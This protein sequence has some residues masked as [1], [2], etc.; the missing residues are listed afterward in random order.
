MNR[1]AVR[2]RTRGSGKL[3][4]RRCLV[5]GAS[6][7]GGAATRRVQGRA[8]HCTARREQRPP[9][10]KLSRRERV[11]AP[12]LTAASSRT[13]NSPEP[14]DMMIAMYYIYYTTV[15]QCS[16]ILNLII[17]SPHIL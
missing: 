17:I 6:R 9:C 8:V 15:V 13:K 3:R 2:S 7:R 5:A 1:A 10:V 11:P 16:E 4:H 12:Q 14:H